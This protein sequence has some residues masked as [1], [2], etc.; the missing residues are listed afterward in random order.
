MKLVKWNN[1]PVFPVVFNRFF[2]DD[3]DNYFTK[4]DCGCMPATNVVENDK[5][6]EIEFAIPGMNR[7]DIKINVENDVLTVSSEKEA[8]KE[9]KDKNYTRKEFSYSSFSRSFT[10]PETVDADQINARL[11]NGILKVD[12]PKK[13]EAKSKLSKEIKVS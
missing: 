3:F 1:D 7:E 5:S 11:E 8:K 2:N 12:L 4:R 9:E 6:F 13:E 10:L